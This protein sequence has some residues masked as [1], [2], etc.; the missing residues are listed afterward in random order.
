MRW[1]RTT[2]P[3]RWR[4]PSGWPAGAVGSSSRA[5]SSSRSAAGVR[6]P[7]I[8]RRAG[9]R[10]VEV[11]TTNRTRVADFATAARRP[12]PGS[13][14]ASTRRTSARRASSRRRSRPSSPSS[15][16]GTGRSWSTTSAAARCSTRRP[17]G[18]PT[19]RRRPSASRP[20]PTWSRSAATSWSG[21]RR[22]GSSSAART[23][24]RACARTRWR[25]RSGPTRRRSP[26]LAATL[27]LYRAGLAAREIP[28]WRMIAAR[29]D[30]LRA[31][32]EALVARLDDPAARC[33]RRAGRLDRRRRIAAGRD[34]AVVGGRRCPASDAAARPRSAGA[35]RRSS[36]GSRPGACCSTSGRSTRRDDDRA[37]PGG[38]GGDAPDAGRS[39]M[40]VVVGTAGHIDHGKTTPAPGADRDR[41]RPAARGAPARDDDRRRLCPPRACPTATS[42]TS[43]TC[44]GHDRLVGNML[45]GAGEI[46]AALLVVA[47]DDGPRAQ[48][49]EHLEL[50]DALGI[51]HG[52]AAVTKIDLVDPARA[53]AVVADVERLLA[54][55][56]L[57]GSPVV[58]VSSSRATGSTT[59]RAALVGLRDRVGRS[60]TAMRG[61]SRGP[62]SGWRSTASSR[63]RAAAR[64][65]P[66]RSAAARSSAGH[67]TPARARRP[68]RPGARGPGPRRPRST[69]SS[70]GG[71][72]ALNLAGVDGA[73][74]V[75][76][77]V[78]TTDS[79]RPHDRSAPRD[80]RRRRPRSTTARS[81]TTSAAHA[82]GR[83]S[84]LHLGT[85]T[86]DATLRR[87]R[88]DAGR[89]ARRPPCGHGCGSPD[90]VAA[91]VGDPFVAPRSR[92]RP[93]P[94]PAG[95]VLDAAPPIG[96]SARR[97]R[98][99]RWPSSRPPGWSA[100][101]RPSSPPASGST[102]SL[103][104]AATASR[105]RRRERGRSPAGCSPR[106]I[107][108][109]ARCGGA[110]PRRR[111]SRRASRSRP[112]RPL[113]ELRRTPRPVAPAPGDGRPSDGRGGHRER[114]PR[115]PR[116]R[117]PAGRAGRRPQRPGA[118]RRA[119]CPPTS[120]PRWIDSRRALAVPA[121]PSF[122][123]AVRRTR[124]AR[125]RA[126]GRSRPPGGSSASTT[127]SPGRDPTLPRPRG[128]RAPTG[129]RGPLTP[130]TL[131]RCDRD[132]PQVRH[133][134]ARGPRSAGRAAPDARTATSAGRGLR[135]EP[136]DRRPTATGIVLA[137]G[138]SSRFGGDKLA[139]PIDGEPLLWRPIRALGGGRLRVDRRGHRA[140]A[141]RSAAP[142]GPRRRSFVWFATRSRSAG[143][144]SGCGPG[145]AA[146]TRLGRDRRRRRPARAPARHCCGSSSR[147]D[148]APTD[149]GLPGGR[150]PSAVVL[151]DPTGVARPLPCV[152]DRERARG[153]GRPT[154]RRW[155]ATAPGA[156]RR[157]RRAR[158]AGG[159]LAFGRPGRLVDPRRRSSGGPPETSLTQHQALRYARDQGG[160]TTM[161]IAAKE[162]IE[163]L[164]TDLG[165]RA[166]VARALARRSLPGDPLA[167]S[168]PG[169]RA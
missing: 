5:A 67:A 40:T 9:A 66:A 121:P 90:P 39:A 102:A 143:R 50:L 103:P 15:P 17:S 51:R 14:S 131:A 154:P 163:S 130:A 108:S 55:T 95:I 58:A 124:A 36:G 150:S 129:D 53:V 140:R 12:E 64:S 162:R 62:G 61:A 28:V 4:S 38:R 72:V 84:A 81:E 138:R 75:R 78:L 148:A 35:S 8:V 115:R 136:G 70:G 85:A 6:I 87:G 151:V 91:A 159:R 45:V 16:I 127:T 24:S 123:E 161:P 157:A 25:A 89:P 23:S 2:T 152:V 43:W 29:P 11:G 153:D 109:R 164:V 147:R 13:S 73:P 119:H 96:A 60:A 107:A 37:G 146:A 126:C 76:G 134:P 104:H 79:G 137:G 160:R 7:E 106:T 65:S 74:P 56:T 155:R 120:V 69:S 110:R 98:R 26:A 149:A 88:R 139:A 97:R 156:H 165:S 68:R 30:D 44:P 57:A 19:S 145:S 77:D 105:R 33:A 114:R 71:R 82:P 112:G 113:A 1:S 83:S 99:R 111:A 31:R 20:A 118:A 86:V 144:W 22:P 46:D 125:R 10:L 63:S 167:R 93:R 100:T 3:R 128:D 48:T 116:G 54:R 117:R 135:D 142:A 101:T 133:G 27:G 42:S 166:E 41:R 49:L 32:A 158:G 21:A 18:S 169:P 122:G 92:R 80:P 59:L 34:A 168:R 132:E 141:R 52:V 94:P 47:A